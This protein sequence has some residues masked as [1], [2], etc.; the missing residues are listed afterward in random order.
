MK[1]RQIEPYVA[2]GLLLASGIISSSCSSAPPPRE[3]LATAELAV[4][5]A[6][7]NKAPQYAPLEFRMATEKADKA[8]QAMRD[9]NYVLA[10]RFAEQALVDAQ[11]AES[12]AQ[13]TEARQTATQLREG[14]EALRREAERGAGRP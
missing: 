14:I 1:R 11:L 6:Q 3:Q 12:K 9:E 13:S 4:R 10:R 8:K 2:I 7:D 5:R